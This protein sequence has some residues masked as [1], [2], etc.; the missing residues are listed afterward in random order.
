[1][2][3]DKKKHY[4]KSRDAAEKMWRL[5][6]YMSPA[7]VE[8]ILSADEGEPFGFEA[9]RK[10][11][12]FMFLDIRNFTEMSDNL[13]PET[14]TDILNEFYSLIDDV[15]KKHNGSINKF[16]GDGLL[17]MFGDPIK[18]RNNKVNAMI[19]GYKI[20]QLV[21]DYSKQVDY[22]PIKFSIGIGINSG[23]AVL[24]AF[25]TS[26]HM[27]YTAIGSNVNIAARLQ[28]V[29][30][31]SEVIVSSSTY[32]GVEDQVK[33]G[34]FRQVKVKGL[35]APLDIADVIGLVGED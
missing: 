16:L 6:R 29:S 8:K 9:K 22:L 34:N 3:K 33:L 32:E 17:I 30:T 4:E 13:E 26:N 7:L 5:E 23:K 28:A 24:G 2:T 27:D 21:E 15:L 12:T 35:D 10:R 14:I 19:A 31:Q 20:M 25:G 1:M 18:D 11:V